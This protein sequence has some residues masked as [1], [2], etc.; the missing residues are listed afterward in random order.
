[1]ISI[2]KEHL[3]DRVLVVVQKKG[4]REDIYR[5]LEREPSVYKVGLTRQG[6]GWDGALLDLKLWIGGHSKGRS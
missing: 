6:T 4:V 1:M 2:K 5:V 3:F